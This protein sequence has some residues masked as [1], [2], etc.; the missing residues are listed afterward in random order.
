MVSHRFASV[1][2]LAGALALPATA[3]SA[4]PKIELGSSAA[5]PG[6][7]AVVSVSLQKNGAALNVIAPLEIEFD[8]SQ[9][10]FDGCTSAAPGKGATVNKNGNRAAVALSGSEAEFPD[11]IIANCTFSVLAGASGTVAVKFVRAGTADVQFND[12]EAQGTNGAITIA[13]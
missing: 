10:T 12:I 7:T 11:G 2:A 1:L 13:P 6:A 3:R 4:A 5:A 8:S 9:V